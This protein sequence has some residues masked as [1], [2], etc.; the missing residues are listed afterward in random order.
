MC[1]LCGKRPKE[2]VRKYL[3]NL[4][5]NLVLRNCAASC[6]ASPR[7][8]NAPEVAHV[9]PSGKRRCDIPCIKLGRYRRYDPESEEFKA[10]LDKQ[11]M[12]V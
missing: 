4:D 2:R 1:S 10:W 12:T 3:S 5:A 6:P 11:R 9:L 8:S 7:V